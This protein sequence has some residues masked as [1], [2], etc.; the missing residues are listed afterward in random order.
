MEKDI[1]QSLIT[2]DISDLLS[3]L[4]QQE[5]KV[6]VPPN[7]PAK[8]EFNKFVN[9]INKERRSNSSIIG[10]RD[11]HN[12]IKRTL[13]VN[14]KN[15]IQFKDEY[16]NL[17]DI[18]VGRGGDLDKWNEAGIKNVYGF[19]LDSESIM[20]INPF[21][22]GARQ[23]LE[24]YRSLHINNVKYSVGSATNPSSELLDDIDNF[25]HENNDTTFKMI[26]C[27]FALHYFFKDE[28]S[29]RTVLAIV[30]KYLKKG[31]FF[32]GTTLDSDFIK[33]ILKENKTH[34]LFDVS[35]DK[36]FKVKLDSP[37]ANKYT[38]EIKDSVDDKG[39]YFNIMGASTE[40]LVDFNIL[41]RLAAEYGL[42]PVYKNFFEPYKVGSKTEYTTIQNFMSFEEIYK[43]N[44]WVPKENGRTM[45]D[46]EL[47]INHLYRT[48]V[49]RK[50]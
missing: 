30:K 22:P 26:S 35:T 9:K 39:N 27:Q 18:A 14:I 36:M 34:N 46:D 11:F 48:F 4:N 5:F 28:R 47:E 1:S 45:N 42:E 29:I 15:Y 24:N 13:I 31:G 32:F 6:K 38:F 43:Q 17:L 7:R 21:N 41:K 3:C 8:V 49:F 50:K 33:Q 10:L 40:Y 44:V 16:I 12:W 20:S 25:I 23:R 19:D 2:L 37:F